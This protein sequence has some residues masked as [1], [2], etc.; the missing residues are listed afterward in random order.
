MC[1]V[2]G[3]DIGEE[4]LDL[5]L[6]AV[7]VGGQHLR[8]RKNLTRGCAGPAPR[9]TSVMLAATSPLS[10]AACCTLREISC[11]AAPCSSTAAAMVC[12]ISEIR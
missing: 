3:A 6:E 11:V 1:R 10:V 4:L 2:S 8:C 5:D 12:E 7:A 9:L